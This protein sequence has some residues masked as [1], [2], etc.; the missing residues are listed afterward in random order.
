[1]TYL[2][3]AIAQID[4]ALLAAL[5]IAE[6]VQAFGLCQPLSDGPSR[7]PAQPLSPGQWRPALPDDLHGLGWYHRLSRLDIATIPG[8][9][10]EDLRQETHF[11]QLVI[12]ARH[13]RAALGTTVGGWLLGALPKTLAMT[14]MTALAAPLR[15]EPSSLEADAEA[16]WA[17]ETRGL[18]L[19]GPGWHFLRLQYRLVARLRPH[20]V[21]EVCL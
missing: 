18:P 21:A 11:L 6:P 1:M 7:Y 15:L 3:T 2:P 9:G 5:N 4:E 19:A 20:C 8:H 13:E 12:W 17:A 14:G 10:P 16:V